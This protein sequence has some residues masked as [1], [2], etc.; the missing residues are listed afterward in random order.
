MRIIFLLLISVVFI[1]YSNAQKHF[2]IKGY[3]PQ[4]K[5]KEIFIKGFTILGDS[6]IS[7]STIDSMGSFKINYPKSYRGAAL[8]EIKDSKSVI[9]LLNKED[10]EIQWENTEKLNSLK[11]ISSAENHFFSEGILVAQRSENLL[12]GLN[13]LYSIYKEDTSTSKQKLQW[14]SNEIIFQKNE[15]NL[16]L[17]LLP[18]DSYVLYYLK[19]RK[20]LQD[21][22]ITSSKLIERMPIHQIEFNKINFASI[23]LL[24]SGL[25]KELLENYFLLIENQRDIET[26]YVSIN[27]STDVILKTL[28][29]HPEIKQEVAAFLFQLFEK[30][31]LFK[32][33]EH[34]ALAMLDNQS[35]EMDFKHQA[36]YEQYRKMSK[37][38][39]A[40]KIVFYN[41]TKPY[42][43]SIDITSK[44]VLVVFGASWCSKCQE[45]I[46]KLKPFYENWK[47][48]YE[49]EIV[50]ISLD[51]ELNSFKKFSADFPW[52]SS[53]ELKG[54]E[55]ASAIDYCV[56][57]S[58]TMYLLDSQNTILMK[59]ISEK[60]IQ[61]WLE[62]Y[63]KQ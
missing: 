12:S 15:F 27:T 58:P 43:S 26:V 34:L 49:L 10:I 5:D 39:T 21:M 17:K 61:A 28:D 57:S 59:P 33:S 31:S 25:Y 35:C 6:L 52:L 44:Y 56:F 2:I 37:G 42:A 48:K 1:N 54:W 53:C 19:L 20:L 36:L 50:Y 29:H 4:A 14:I 60:Q 41:A 8:L 24:H 13:Y 18:L 7:K 63:H 30:R 38:K 62:M 16:F 51:T 47:T 23:N 32:A 3:I 9:L 40:P 45:E 22:S 11:Y 55:S 46:P